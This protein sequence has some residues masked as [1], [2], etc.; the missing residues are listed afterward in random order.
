MR[1]TV[2][3]DYAFRVLIYVAGRP[4]Q[5]ATIAQIAGA[6]RISEHHLTK[7]VHELGRGGFLANVRGRGG[8]IELARPPHEIG[9]GAVLRHMEPATAPVACFDPRSPACRIA[10]A[11]RLRGVIDEATRAFHAV[12]DR[13][14]LADLLGDN[15]Q[16]L[17]ELLYH[18]AASSA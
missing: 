3:T 10:P 16:A 13:H 17:A 4:G 9:V 6:F 8:G 2:F 11:C 12:L 1:L 18:G 5:R 7:V 14:T 15:R